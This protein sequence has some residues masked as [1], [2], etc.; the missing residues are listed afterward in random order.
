MPVSTKPQPDAYEHVN[1][2]IEK[3]KSD[4]AFRARVLAIEGV[5][6][7]MQFLKREGFECKAGDVQLYLQSYVAKDGSQL[8]VL[9]EAG[10]CKGI[11]YGFCF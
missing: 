10:G 2:V 6:A 9:T 4:T 1:A 3:M 11:Y 8:V 5:D 7:R